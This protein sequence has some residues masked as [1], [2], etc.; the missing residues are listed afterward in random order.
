LA[1]GSPEWKS[2][3]WQKTP[4]DLKDILVDV[5]VDMPGLVEEF[6]NMRLCHETGKQ[7]TLR[8]K[9][10][11]GCWEHDRRLLGWLDLLQRLI[12]PVNRP[13]ETRDPVTHVAQVHGMGLFWVTSLVLYS[14]LWEVSSSKETP[15]ERANPLLYARHLVDAIHILLQ[16]SSG[17]Y[18]IQSAILV[19]QAAL[20][21]IPKIPAPLISIRPLLVV[22]SPLRA[23]Y[24][25]RLARLEN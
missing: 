10:L 14:I 6:D 18:G 16:P 2:I 22:L 21:Y 4:K 5:L 7:E 23:A 24:V 17:L 3:P 25:D 1:L 15:P 13:Q 20:E 9:L 12:N 19:L 8:L 11:E